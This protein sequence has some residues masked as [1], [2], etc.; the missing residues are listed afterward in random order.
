MRHSIFMLRAGAA[1]VALGLALL[2]APAMAQDAAQPTEEA[3]DAGTIVVTGSRINRPDLEQSSPVAVIGAD[4]ISRRGA[5]SVEQVLR[6][7]PGSTA[8]INPGVNN[9]AT[10][11]ASF[12]LRG[13]GT[14]RNLVLLNGRR[15]VPSTLTNIVDL[16]VIPVALVERTD[17]LT[18]GAVTNYGADAIAGV[19][20][21]VTRRDFTGF[22]VAAQYGVSERGDGQGYRID[23]TTGAELNGGQG[24][25]VLGLSYT[26]TKPVVQGSRDLGTVS[27]ASTCSTAQ[28]VSGVCPDTVLR[29]SAQG[30]NTAV[31]ASLFA[32][33]PLSAA[34][35]SFPNTVIDPTRSGGA[36]F[37]PATGTIAPGLSDYNF[38]PLNYYQTP[39]DRW[40]A[41]AAGHYEV[42]DTIEVYSEAM[43]MRSRVVQN[44]APTGTFTEQFGLPLNNQ[45]LTPAQ[46]AQLCSFANIADCPTA[47]ASGQEVTAIVARRFVETG[48]RVGTFTSNMFQITAGAR[49]KLTDTLNWDVFGQYG[50]SERIRVDTGTALR[51]RVQ[52]ALRGCPTG[53]SAGCAPINLFGAEGS[54]TPAMLAFVGVPTTQTTKSEFSSAQALVSGDLGFSSP[55]TDSPIGIAAGAEY[56]RYGGSQL[57]DLPNQQPG[58]ILGSGGAFLTVDEG[59][60]SNEF[61]GEVIAP[62]V[63]DRPFFY[64]LTLEAGIRYADYSTTGGNTTWKVGGSWA[65]VRDI[66]FRAAYTRAVRAPNIGELYTPRL[67]GLNNLAAEPCQGNVT[68]ATTRTLCIA[69]LAA[70]GLTAG[71]LGNVPAPIAGQV[72]QTTEGNPNLQPEQATTI[73]VGAVFQPSFIPGLTATL[74]WYR[75]RVTDAITEPTVGDILN[76]CFGQSNPNDPRC[77]SIRRNPLTGGLSGSTATTEGIIRISSNQGRLET[78]GYDLTL[79]YDRQFGDVRLGIATQGNYTTKS[80]FQSNPSSFNRECAGFYSVSCDPVLPKWTFNTRATIGFEKVDVSLLWRYID[81][82]RYEPRTGANATTPPAAGTVGSFGSVDPA[83]VVPNYRAIDAYNYFDLNIGFNI[84]DDVRLSMLV[85]NL[86]DKAAPEVGNTIGSTAFNSGNTYPSMYDAIGRRFTMSARLRF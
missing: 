3:A 16:N 35:A 20:N 21:F 31:P 28:R 83:I 77:L 42:T 81:G 66:K 2:A 12:N 37:D 8:G 86:F 55:F 62:I 30:S 52:Q 61:F 24:N 15:I 32:P 65:P 34:S 4:E 57:G 1:P 76:G 85:E 23:L 26:N 47:I 79:A 64:N 75:I 82:V 46:S 11:I 17:V 59:F 13:L 36:Q 70:A 58:E 14:N 84:T 80:R 6:Q 45:F 50:E 43:F 40:S 39:M 41:Y 38:N 72:N 63:T 54:L 67:T 5:I 53:S 44:L 22:E 74:D 68:N 33:L 56:R 78:E 19:V 49:G 10:G 71:S 48:P 18:G 25:V 73:T 7:L 60:H 27:R 9:G 29:G 51:S 69:Q